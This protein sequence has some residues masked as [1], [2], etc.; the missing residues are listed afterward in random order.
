[1]QIINLCLCVC[2]CVQPPHS[3]AINLF[4]FYC[5]SSSRTFCWL[6]VSQVDRWWLHQQ[7]LQHLLEIHYNC[8]P[9]LSLSLWAVTD[10]FVISAY[11]EKWDTPVSVKAP[12]NFVVNLAHSPRPS[13]SLSLPCWPASLALDST[14]SH[15]IIWPKQVAYYQTQH[16]HTVV[17]L[18]SEIQESR[19][20]NRVESTVRMLSILPPK[21]PLTSAAANFDFEYV[22]LLFNNYREAVVVAVY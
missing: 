5:C 9:T 2:V 10:C 21:N 13:L 8:E 7:Q 12:A 6:E 15:G 18:C 4:Y 19:I 22:L 14:T 16:T 1:M 11:S 17:L 3:A 20:E